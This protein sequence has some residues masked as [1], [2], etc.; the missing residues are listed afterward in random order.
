MLVASFSRLAS[1]FFC[2]GHQETDGGGNIVVAEV[3]IKRRQGRRGDRGGL[4]PLGLP[5]STVI[6]NNSTGG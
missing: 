6:G 4:H 2:L 3:N 1:E 5:V